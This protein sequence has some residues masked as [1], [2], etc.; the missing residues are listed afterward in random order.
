MQVQEGT[1]AGKVT[2][3]IWTLSRLSV[4]G[5]GL[6]LRVERMTTSE[7]DLKLIHGN[8]RNIDYVLYLERIKM[9]THPAEHTRHL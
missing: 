9:L 7:Q 6:R 8:L 1:M 5:R 4:S 2:V 3:I